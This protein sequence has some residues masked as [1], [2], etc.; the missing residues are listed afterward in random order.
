MR[1]QVQDDLAWECFE[2]AVQCYRVVFKAEPPLKPFAKAQ[3]AIADLVERWPALTIED[4]T[5]RFTT[6]LRS[7]NF[8]RVE[9]FCDD[10]PQYG[11]KEVKTSAANRIDPATA[12]KGFAKLLRQ[13]GS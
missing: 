13:T 6:C 5:I 12:S 4:F 2:A 1:T 8:K 10:Y 7:G 11:K 3:D 9:W